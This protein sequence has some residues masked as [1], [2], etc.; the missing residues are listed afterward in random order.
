MRFGVLGTLTAEGPDGPVELGA[1]KQRAVLALLLL[2]ANRVV[3]VDR[4]IDDLWSGEPPPGALGT[5]HAYVSVLRRILEPGRAPRAQ[6]TVIISMAPGY[7]LRVEPADLDVLRFEEIVDTAWRMIDDDPVAAIGQLEAA[8]ALWRGPLMAE[9]ADES[10]VRDAAV[11]LDERRASALEARLQLLVSLGGSADVVSDLEA[12]VQ[13]YPLREGLWAL[14][15]LTQYRLGRQADALRSF[16]RVR[17]FLLTELGLDPGAEL[18][19]IER[20]IL[21]QDPLLLDP[22]NGAPTGSPA[23]RRDRAPARPRGQRRVHGTGR[24]AP[25]DRV[26]LATR[27]TTVAAGR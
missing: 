13:M 16:Q 1:P 9:F 11:R 4:I 6:S 8:L 21:E 24:P 19:T 7:M 10:W 15:M 18:Q 14:L 22:T 17:E 20:R 5:V 27:C 12:A 2:S 3:S 25:R 23:L 26:V